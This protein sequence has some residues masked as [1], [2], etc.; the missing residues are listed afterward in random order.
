[1]VQNT[2]LALTTYILSTYHVF[3]LYVLGRIM[4]CYFPHVFRPSISS[5]FKTRKVTDAVTS[6]AQTDRNESFNR[7]LGS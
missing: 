7:I 6:C 1:M 3:T 4:Y 2:Y 5:A